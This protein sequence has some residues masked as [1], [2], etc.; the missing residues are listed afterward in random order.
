MGGGAVIGVSKCFMAFLKG[1]AK[2]VAAV[3]QYANLSGLA[4]WRHLWLSANSKITSR[5]G[6]GK[7]NPA[8]DLEHVHLIRFTLLGVE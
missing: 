3:S 5:P 8:C 1:Q 4:V 6:P 2:D 7:K